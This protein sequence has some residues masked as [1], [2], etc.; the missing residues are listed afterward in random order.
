V[1]TSFQ[2]HSIV[3]VNLTHCYVVAEATP[4]IGLTQR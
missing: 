3:A 4:M 2:A 1:Q